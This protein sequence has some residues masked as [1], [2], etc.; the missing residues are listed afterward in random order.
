MSVAP[1]YRQQT[2]LIKPVKTSNLHPVKDKTCF[3]TG[4]E[5]ICL[6]LKLAPN[7]NDTNHKPGLTASVCVCARARACAWGGA[8]QPHLLLR[9]RASGDSQSARGR[10][11]NREK[12]SASLKLQLQV[13]QLVLFRFSKWFLQNKSCDSFQPD[14]S[15]VTEKEGR[16]VLSRFQAKGCRS[17]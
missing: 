8:G 1:G 13:L 7:R 11:H 4:K 12:P 3:H 6:E 2:R 15:P 9:T 10:V 17:G 16:T 14:S 5:Q